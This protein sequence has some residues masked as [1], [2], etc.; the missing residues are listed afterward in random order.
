MNSLQNT[1]SITLHELTESRLQL[2][3]AVQFIAAIGSALAEPK[4]DYSHTSLGWNPELKAFVGEVIKGKQ[5]FQVA[6]D[7]VSLT[8]LILDEESNRLAEFTLH[9]KTIAQGLNWHK[10]EISKLGADADRVTLLAYP[11]DDFPDCAVARGTPFD[12]SQ[13]AERKQLTDYYATT[14]LVLQEIVAITAGISPIHT[15][16][17]HFDM[18]TLISL[19]GRKNGEQMSIGIG[20]SPGDKSYDEP[21]W[22]VSPWPYPDITKLPELDAGGFW[23]TQH[24]VGAVLKASQ[25]SEG[26]TADAQ[27]EQVRLFLH[28]ALKAANGLLQGEG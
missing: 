4:P 2:H 3:Y 23:H 17:H 15:W 1:N 19:P 10:D 20:M 11:P 6:L 25:L 21:Y 8:S 28:S 13:E 24:W 7:P 27:K 22:Y 16:P 5:V 12:A 14:Y 26:K 18:A 9:G